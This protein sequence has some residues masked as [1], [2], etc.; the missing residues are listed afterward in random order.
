[1]PT[2]C[3]LARPRDNIK[4]N[5]QCIPTEVVRHPAIRLASK[6]GSFAK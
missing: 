3:P 4:T 1:M 2:L 5:K 6:N